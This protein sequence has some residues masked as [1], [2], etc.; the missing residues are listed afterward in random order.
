MK[1]QKKYSFSL[2]FFHLRVVDGGR[3]RRG[4]RRSHRNDGGL[5]QLLVKGP[6]L[7]RVRRRRLGS[8]GALAAR[9]LGASGLGGR[10]VI[11][12]DARKRVRPERDAAVAAADARPGG[13]LGPKPVQPPL[14]VERQA[15]V[16]ALGGGPGA[17]GDGPARVPQ[18]RRGACRRARGPELG[19]LQALHLLRRVDAGAGVVG[20]LDGRGPVDDGA[21]GLGG[22]ARRAAAQDLVPGGAGPVLAERRAEGGPSGR[23]LSKLVEGQGREA[24]GEGGAGCLAGDAGGGGV[25][26][27]AEAVRG[28]GGQGGFC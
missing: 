7:S 1:K 28:G 26:A 19:P 3:G 2:P 4:R 16:V 20:G 17:D 15:R 8:V 9:R 27:R 24:P 13:D 5:H 14:L 25:E 10:P 12:A 11:D 21:G 18:K 22:E 23:A 6:L